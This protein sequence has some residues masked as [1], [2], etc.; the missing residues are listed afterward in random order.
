MKSEFPIQWGDNMPVQAPF[1][2]SPN[3]PQYCKDRKTINV[4]CQGD[5]KTIRRYLEPTPFSYLTDQFILSFG[6][7]SNGTAASFFDA[8]IILP[9]RYKDV[10]GG[11]YLIEYE[12]LASSVSGGR[13]LWGYP[14]KMAD[15]SMTEEAGKIT[16]A[17]SREG[18]EIIRIEL[19][20]NR[21]P[22]EALPELGSKPQLL[23][24]TMP[25][26]GGPGIQ[27]QKILSRDT[28]VDF[29]VREEKEVFARVK[30]SGYE[31][32]PILEPLDEWNPIRI[33]GAQVAV[34]DYAC[35]EENGWAKLV[36][37]VIPDPDFKCR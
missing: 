26:Y 30:L 16:A 8:G 25:R 20:T 27:C 33:Y 5:E 22:Q 28:S 4:Y 31:N 11:Y 12:D 19:D 18:H 6:D 14:K 2:K 10:I 13:E 29:V 32:P 21:G 17:V 9:V 36:D 37:V 7:Y 34:G 15:F 1:Y 3:N 35:T 24:W 23:L